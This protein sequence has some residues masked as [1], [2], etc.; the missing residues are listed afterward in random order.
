MKRMSKGVNGHL[1]FGVGIAVMLASLFFLPQPASAGDV[2]GVTGKT[3]IVQPAGRVSWADMLKYE[4]LA[5]KISRPRRVIPFMPAPGGKE[6]GSPGAKPGSLTPQ[7]VSPPGVSF[8]SQAPALLSNFEAL[9]DNNTAIPPDTMGA[10]GP[11]HLMTMLNSEV[12]I[13]NKDG[14]GGRRVSLDTFWT[15][16]TGLTGDPFDPKVIFDSLSNRWIATCDADPGLASSQVFFAISDSDDPTGTWTFYSFTADET[17]TDWADYPGFG[18]NN[19][20]IAITNNMFTV[21][22]GSFSG[23]KM[24]VIKK[25]TALTGGPLTVTVFPTGFDNGGGY[26]GFTLKPALTFDAAQSKLYIVDNS[27]YYDNSGTYLLRL[28]E[29]TGTD[30]PVWQATAG[31]SV[32]QYSGFFPVANNFNY[33]QIN[34]SQK[35]DTTL[36]ATNDPRILNVVVRNGKVWA[37]HTGGLPVASVGSADRTAVFWYQLD[38]ASMPNPIVQSGVLDPGAGGHVFF[39][40]IA[41]NAQEDAVI[42]FSRS[43]SNRYV[44]AAF[45]GRSHTDAPGTMQSISVLKSGEDSYI[46]D[47]GSGS[48]RWGDY[49]ATCVDPSDD[50]TFWTIQEYAAQDVGPGPDDDRWGTWWGKISLGIEAYNIS[51]TVIDAETGN[52]VANVPVEWNVEISGNS[53]YGSTTTL[54]DGTFS[55]TDVPAGEVELKAKPGVDSGYAYAYS[56][57][58]LS[59]DTTGITM[60]LKKGAVVIGWVRDTSGSGL[61]GLDVVVTGVRESFST[62]TSS[63]PNAGDGF[64]M[65]RL[66]PGRYTLYLDEDNY[67]ALSYFDVRIENETDRMYVYNF[68]AYTQQELSTITG[69]ITNSGGYPVNGVLLVVAFPA[70]IEITTEN[71]NMINPIDEASPDQNGDY[72][73]N[74]PPGQSYQLYFGVMYQSPVANENVWA[75]AIRDSREVAAGSTGVNFAYSSGGGTVSGNVQNTGSSPVAYAYAVLKD[76]SGSFLGFALTDHNGDYAIYNVAPGS[77]YSLVTSEGKLGV[78]SHSST[79][80][81]SDGGT[82]S[83][84]DV[85]YNI[86]SDVPDAPLGL[87][88]YSADT[89]A[90]LKWLSNAESSTTGYKIYR[91]TSANGPFTLI[92]AVGAGTFTYDDTGLNNGTTYYYYVTASGSESGH[93]SPQEVTPRDDQVIRDLYSSFETYFE[94]ENHTAVMGYFSPDY[95]DEGENYSNMSTN[96]QQLFDNYHDLAI[97]FTINHIWF[98]GDNAIVNR[99]MEMSRVADTDNLTETES[100]TGDDYLQYNGSWKL[101]GDQKIAFPEVKSTHWW[102]S[103]YWGMRLSVES[104]SVTLD[105]AIVFAPDGTSPGLTWNASDESFQYAKTFTGVQTPASGRWNFL[106]AAQDGTA[107]II[108]RT[109][110]GETLDIPSGV[111]VRQLANGDVQVSWDAVSNTSSY[112]VEISGNGVDVYRDDIPSADTSYTFSNPGLVTGNTYTVIV[113]AYRDN[114]KG[115]G[116]AE[117]WRETNVTVTPQLTISKIDSPDPVNAGSNLTYTIT[118]GNTGAQDASGVVIRDTVPANTTFVSATN[119]GTLQGSDVVWNI[120][121]L[122]AGV[123]GQTVQFTVQVNAGVADGTILHNNTYSI[124]CDQT[125]Q[126]DGADVTTTVNNAPILNVDPT[127]LD[128][129]STDT[130]ETFDITNTGTGTL[131]W[132]TGAVV[133]NQGSGWITSISPD[134]GTTTTETDTVS[135]TINRAGLAAGTY[136]ATIPVTSNGGNQDVAVSM[137]VPAVPVLNVNPTSLD[138]GSTDTQKT[139]NI[140]NQGTGTLTWSITKDKTWITVN[141]T[142]GDTTVE[143]DVITVSVD[144]SGLAPGHYTG[145][146]SITSNGGNQDV[147]VDMDVPGLG[148]T[149]TSLDFGSTDTQKTFAITNTGSGTL[150]WQVTPQ[151]AWIAAN[152]LNGTDATTITVSVDRSGLAPGHYTGTVSVTSNGGNQDVTVDM[153]VPGLGINPTSLDLGDSDLVK[154]FNITNTGSGT[155]SWNTGAVVYNQGSGWITNVSPSS[156]TT[157]TETDTVSVTVNRAGLAAGTY[158]ATIPVTSDGGNQDVTVSMEVPVITNPQLAVSPVNPS[159]KLYL[160]D[161]PMLVITNA[162]SLGYT[163]IG[164]RWYIWDADTGDTVLQV[165]GESSSNE[166]DT[167]DT[168]QLRIPD[169]VLEP[170]TAQPGVPEWLSK[171]DVPSGNYQAK[172]VVM[173]QQT[174]TVG[175]NTFSF[176]TVE[177]AESDDTDDN[178]VPDNEELTE[179]EWDTFLV[180]YPSADTALH[181]VASGDSNIIGMEVDKGKITQADALDTDN[182]PDSPSGYNFPYGVFTVRVE[183]LAQ[184]D[185]VLITYILPQAFVGHWWKYDQ[186]NGWQDYSSHVVEYDGVNKTV[187]IEVKDGGYGDADGVANG[188][189]VDPSGPG[190]STSGGG[191]GG[192]GGGCFISILGRRYFRRR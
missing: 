69:N 46:K 20:W 138:F 50:T 95:L 29:V 126:V 33:T 192:G 131:N 48:V 63:D 146:V 58:Y 79:V 166:W 101:Y 162:G 159:G 125:A 24:W 84:V 89:Y 90:H 9:P 92:D 109:Y 155:L 22:G 135:V 99:T 42:G 17:G 13:Q 61:N 55:F 174:V 47:F 191:G 36:I 120:G 15:S 110:S 82:T 85:T 27:G 19:N 88:V 70:G 93:F 94:S 184:G 152:P 80:S 43:D 176:S 74:V 39:P 32:Q 140:T 105:T 145:T 111:T 157:T 164:T 6:I 160:D 130:Q 75:F 3:I 107:Q 35:G 150:T 1:V 67:S 40:S 132:N 14:S 143:T 8:S 175:S 112:Q 117:S 83:N 142:S 76:S 154:T 71:I 124:D 172:V 16:G 68:I 187:T 49:S 113:S 180:E 62:E 53:Y 54:A 118:Y 45:T 133:Y 18:V 114:A 116:V 77:S 41:V 181:E 128:F 139:F 121:A 2:A 182:L 25:S 173:N 161:D 86:A 179:D 65:V 52:P 37:T 156:G 34:A 96:L 144:R 57:F 59:R 44:E 87:K 104:E 167:Q 106:V 123:T 122:S 190:V 26:T 98:D 66:A 147:T 151:E 170:S 51:G 134:S 185:T 23:A 149:P 12:R 137:E 11:N 73:L 178:G 72:T 31:S 91:S 186:V 136:T 129:G 168:A 165:P 56:H 102:G 108:D 81:V 21:S 189:V 5:P 163:I 153:D 97:N 7:P 10:V 78:E 188:V 127:S 100:E 171:L 158:T 183:E 115:E 64:F 103:E 119:G 60:K 177:P 141:P 38:P 169:G 148:V 30:T 4:A 28:S